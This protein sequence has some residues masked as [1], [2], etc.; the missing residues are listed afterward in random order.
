M[1]IYLFILNSLVPVQYIPCALARKYD[2]IIIAHGFG[3]YSYLLLLFTTRW[4][5]VP[6]KQKS[7][8]SPSIFSNIN[9]YKQRR[10][11]S[12]QQKLKQPQHLT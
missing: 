8:L 2:T 3:H 7:D 4:A 5:S 10:V 9:P 1:S 6:L 12:G 11:P